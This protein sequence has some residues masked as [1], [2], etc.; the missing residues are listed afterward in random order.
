MLRARYLFKFLTKITTTN[1][2]TKIQKLNP[3]LTQLNIENATH[4]DDFLNDFF[5]K[6]VDKDFPEINCFDS[7][8]YFHLYLILWNHE[9]AFSSFW[10]QLFPLENYLKFFNLEKKYKSP[11][12]FLNKKKQFYFY[13]F[14]CSNY[15]WST[16]L[17][18]FFSLKNLLKM[19]TFFGYVTSYK[20]R[21]KMLGKKTNFRRK[22]QKKGF[23]E[24]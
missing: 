2:E 10:I 19:K 22:F 1:Y 21:S 4:L 14:F 18:Y 11:Q 7:I 23:N 15:F 24:Y 13:I 5:F 3:I 9:H 6:D 16:D 17:N 12:F 20:G 8:W